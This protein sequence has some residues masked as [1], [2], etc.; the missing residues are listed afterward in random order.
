LKNFV[1]NLIKFWIKTSLHLYH[2]SIT[3]KGLE[4]VPADKPVLFLPNHQNALL[5]PLLIA[6]DCNR[7]PYFLTRS[8]VF[9]SSVLNRLFDLVRMIP[10]YRIRDGRDSLRHNE[11]VFERC[12]KLLSN[13]ESLLMFPEA[14]HNLKRRVRP[15]SK[16]FTRILFKTLEEDPSLDIRLIPVGFNYLY[17]EDFP[18]KVAIYFGKDIVLQ[19]LLQEDDERATIEKIK[20]EVSEALKKLTTHIP[21]ENYQETIEKLDTLDAD[22]LDPTQTNNI[23]RD[24]ESVRER[25]KVKPGKSLFGKVYLPF[26]LLLNL[27]VVLLW[28]L[29]MKPKVWEPEFTATLR[30]AI[31]LVAFPIY[32]VLLFTGLSFWIGPLIAIGFVLALFVFNWGYVKLD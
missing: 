31:A 22:Y 30:F 5:D 14:N 26:F 11:A 9:K 18:D 10:I 20:Y 19:K 21:K 2:G 24:S 15:L 3:V 25:T 16:G 32:Y 23:L 17:G 28:K 8:D 7:K 29:W 4:N 6:V 1:Y 27:P 12:A 13:N